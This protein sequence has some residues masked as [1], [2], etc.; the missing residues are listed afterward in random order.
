MPQKVWHLCGFL[1]IM[2]GVL[3]F[4]VVFFKL[5][6]LRVKDISGFIRNLDHLASA[7]LKAAVAY[8]FIQTAG[9]L[10]FVRKEWQSRSPEKRR[11]KRQ[12]TLSTPP[13]PNEKRPEAVPKKPEPA[14]KDMLEA[15]DDYWLPKQIDML[16]EKESS[17]SRDELY[18]VSVEKRKYTESPKMQF[19]FKDRR[20][21]LNNMDRKNTDPVH[22]MQVDTGDLEGVEV[23]PGKFHVRPTKESLP[24]CVLRYSAVTACFHVNHLPRPGKRIQVRCDKPAVLCKTG[25]NSYEL[26]EKGELTEISIVE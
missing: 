25:I 4:F 3:L 2:M 20:S 1:A 18:P 5:D 6:I 11:G 15:E 10:L 12:T 24:E 22:L 8:F 16:R 17:A 19:D 7:F 26:I 9:M 13:E 14:P 21:S 23:Q